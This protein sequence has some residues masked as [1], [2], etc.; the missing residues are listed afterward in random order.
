MLCDVEE[1]IAKPMNAQ[2][3]PL[4]L[5]NNAIF[6]LSLTAWAPCNLYP[7]LVQVN[8][9]LLLIQPCSVLLPACLLV[10]LCYWFVFLFFIFVSLLP[11]PKSSCFRCFSRDRLQI[12]TGWHQSLLSL[13]KR[14]YEDVY[15][16]AHGYWASS[17]LALALGWFLS[18]TAFCL[19]SWCSLFSAPL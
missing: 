14:T 4:D 16:V 2:R 11:T 8:H 1:T 7:I 9:H 18:I 5:V 13:F 6:C 15:D 19:I 3:R 12:S 10:R 17:S